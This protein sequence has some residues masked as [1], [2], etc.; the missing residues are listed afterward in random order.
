MRDRKAKSRRGDVNTQKRLALIEEIAKEET[1]QY[2]SKHKTYKTIMIQYHNAGEA[3][4]F[5]SALPSLKLPL[6][7]VVTAFRNVFNNEE[8]SGT[9][10]ALGGSSARIYN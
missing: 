3:L 9:F 8:T 5:E 1:V 10:P 4:I 7:R 6:S 2:G